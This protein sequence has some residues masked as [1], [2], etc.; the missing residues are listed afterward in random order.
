MNT[1]SSRIPNEFKEEFL[2]NLFD[3]NANR[4]IIL[5]LV[6][7]GIETIL[8]LIVL[9][10][11]SLSKG[12]YNILVIIMVFI[13]M[14]L[15]FS[16]LLHYLKNKNSMKML[17]LAF[18]LILF[19]TILIAISNT[20]VA[21]AVI[22]DITIYITALYVITAFIRLPIAYYIGIYGLSFIYFAIGM[23]FVQTDTHFV[24]W[25]ILNGFMLNIIAIIIAKMLYDQTVEI[26]LNQKKI[27]QQVE[28]LRYLSQHDGLTNLYNHQTITQIIE[29]QKE[30]S[31]ASKENLCLAI[32]D[33]DNFKKINDEYGHL[34]GDTVLK[35]IAKKIQE[36]VRKDDYVAR[37]GGDEFLILFP[38][39]TISEAN[40]I[41][42]RILR[43]INQPGEDHI[44]ITGSIGLVDLKDTNYDDFIEM[45]DM[46]MYQA[47][48]SGK[49]QIVY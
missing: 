18:I 12:L 35:E 34:I 25:S 38:N 14:S 43:K 26:F 5:F 29:N 2:K 27:D 28:N 21:Q 3:M 40:K 42:E 49:A 48:N 4:M 36:S 9:I 31:K 23:Q 19:L 41:C 6:L 46:K 11:D 32:I 16:F 1:K 20:F 7:A 24:K 39:I 13:F 15:L 47:K 37:Y 10:Y 17:R 30:L 44:S 33:I 22:S 8:F 45:A